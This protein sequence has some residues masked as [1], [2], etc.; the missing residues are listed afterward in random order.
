MHFA[1]TGP[2]DKVFGVVRNG[3]ETITLNRPEPRNA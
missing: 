3:V 2:G 1:G